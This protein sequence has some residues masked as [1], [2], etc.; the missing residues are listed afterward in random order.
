M[1]WLKQIRRD[2][3]KQIRQDRIFSVMLCLIFAHIVEICISVFAYKLM[4]SKPKFGSLIVKPSFR[5]Q[6]YKVSLKIKAE[7]YVKPFFCAI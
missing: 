2:E 6:I 1:L 7:V 4:L 5:G 3:Q